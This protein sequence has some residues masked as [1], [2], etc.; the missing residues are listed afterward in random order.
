MGCISTFD[1]LY[2]KGKIHWKIKHLQNCNLYPYQFSKKKGVIDKSERMKR[3]P[4][5]TARPVPTFPLSTPGLYTTFVNCICLCSIFFSFSII[6]LRQHNGRVAIVT[7]GDGDI[8][9][10]TVRAL[11][12]HGMHVIIGEI[13][14]FGK[15]LILNIWA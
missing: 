11:C 3:H 8:G 5:W 1:S 9:M 14:P 7:G 2:A 4:F 6:D 13:L 10:E 15:C 12:R